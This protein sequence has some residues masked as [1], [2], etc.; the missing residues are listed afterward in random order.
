MALAACFGCPDSVY[1]MLFH[2]SAVVK[3]PEQE[4][5]RWTVTTQYAGAEGEWRMGGPDTTSLRLWLESHFG[6]S[7]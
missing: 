1:C 3:Q 5:Q 6:V 7:L 2:M 4:Q